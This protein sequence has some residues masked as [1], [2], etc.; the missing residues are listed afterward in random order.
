MYTLFYRVYYHYILLAFN[1]DIL[2]DFL[3]DSLL[4]FLPVVLDFLDLV[5]RTGW[6]LWVSVLLDL[7]VVGGVSFWASSGEDF[8][9]RSTVVRL[10]IS[11]CKSHAVIVVGGRPTFPRNAQSRVLL[12]GIS[13][14]YSSFTYW[15]T[16]W[17]CIVLQ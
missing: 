10:S 1:L 17:D 16:P 12:Q 9:P 3:A 14:W 6:C 4:L 15:T 2:V 11:S 7:L 5:T 8:E 13:A